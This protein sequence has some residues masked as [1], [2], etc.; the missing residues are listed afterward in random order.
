[1]RVGGG[2]CQKQQSYY[3]VYRHTLGFGSLAEITLEFKGYFP[4]V[5]V[6]II[7]SFQQ[8]SQL[9]SRNMALG[10]SHLQQF[11]EILGQPWRVSGG[12]PDHRVL[13]L[14][15]D[16]WPCAC[17]HAAVAASDASARGP[18]CGCETCYRP[19]AHLIASV[20]VVRARSAELAGW[21]GARARTARAPMHDATNAHDA[22]CFGGARRQPAV[23]GVGCVA[24]VLQIRCMHAC[25]ISLGSDASTLI[26]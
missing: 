19:L 20:L 7:C 11:M 10:A 21:G 17:W 3:L 5:Y 14:P 4:T 22:S 12:A 13:T 8:T 2:H 9:V 18:V 15:L 26:V 16:R 6:Y 25:L 24:I 23:H 1:M